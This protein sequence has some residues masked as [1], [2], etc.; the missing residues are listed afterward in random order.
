MRLG[1]AYPEPHTWRPYQL[2]QAWA[3]EE[4]ASSHA[5]SG[6]PPASA[7]SSDTTNASPVVLAR[8]VG[9]VGMGAVESATKA[10]SS[11]QAQQQQQRRRPQQPPQ[12]QPKVW[13]VTA[14]P[15]AASQL[16]GMAEA[17]E[18]RGRGGAP[19]EPISFESYL[20][21]KSMYLDMLA[22]ARRGRNRTQAQAV[23]V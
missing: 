21:M 13:R 2:P 10:Q 17:R 16:K 18:S 9:A 14:R 6:K 19:I 4:H 11:K 12:Q 1:I 3:P 7:S 5:S 23:T 22:H 8:P 20:S 15:T